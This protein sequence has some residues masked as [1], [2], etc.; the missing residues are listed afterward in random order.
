MICNSNV[1]S[2]NN[3]DNKQSTTVM[4]KNMMSP[5]NTTTKQVDDDDVD[6]PRIVRKILSGTKKTRSSSRNHTKEW[7]IN[8][9]VECVVNKRSLYGAV[10]SGLPAFFKAI[11][12]NK[13][14][15]ISTKEF[16]EALSRLGLGLDHQQVE[17]VCESIGSKKPGRNGN[18][19]YVDF[20]RTLKDISKINE[21]TKNIKRKRLCF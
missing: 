21:R 14:G 11:D 6:G 17:D 15:I 8:K 7:A 12:R 13:D 10:M 9:I 3:D 4:N 18:I 16:G 19:K 2:S 1:I 20:L 5:A